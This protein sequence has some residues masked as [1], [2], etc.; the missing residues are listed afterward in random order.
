MVTLGIKMRLTRPLKELMTVAERI[1]TEGTYGHRAKKLSE[2]EFGKLTTLFNQMMDSLAESNRRLLE[3]KNDMEDRVKERTLDLTIA[4]QRII[5]EMNQKEKATSELI[6]TKDQLNKREKLASVGQVS[7]NI[8]H[9][10]AQPHGR[11]SQLRLFPST[12][13]RR[14]PQGH[15]SP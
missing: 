4:N 11:D 1:S 6:Q 15:P 13:E 2:D 12:Q 14:R 8:A 9:E 5:A 7:S 3:S 10:L